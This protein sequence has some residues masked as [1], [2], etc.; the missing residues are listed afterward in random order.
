MSLSPSF[1]DVVA[2]WR[3][4]CLPLRRQNLPPRSVL[5][6]KIDLHS[7]FSPQKNRGFFA[8]SCVRQYSTI[9]APSRQGSSA[10]F[11]RDIKYVI[12]DMSLLFCGVA[13]SRRGCRHQPINIR[14]NKSTHGRNVLASTDPPNDPITPV[15]ARGHLLLDGQHSQ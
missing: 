15:I 7:H 5:S 11:D 4:S 10:R 14:Q 9:T 12:I 1:G 13:S 8:S 2:R 3:G 6:T